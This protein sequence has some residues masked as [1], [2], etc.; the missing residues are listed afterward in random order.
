MSTCILC[1]EYLDVTGKCPMQSCHEIEADRDRLAALIANSNLEEVPAT[2]VDMSSGAP[3]VVSAGTMLVPKGQM[4]REKEL[5]ALLA[6]RAKQARE[7]ARL[8]ARVAELE[9]NEKRM[10]DDVERHAEAIRSLIGLKESTK[11]GVIT[12]EVSHKCAELIANALAPMLARAQNYVECKLDNRA[13]EAFTL[14]LQKSAGKTPHRLRLEAEAE[15]EQAKA[16]VAELERR[17]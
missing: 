12:I 9:V 2:R 7:N 10:A 15:L 13:G 4:E 3:V 5:T 8:A 14:I 16:R 17:P 1:G 11:E 6:E